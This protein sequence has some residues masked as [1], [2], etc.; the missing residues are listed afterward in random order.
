MGLSQGRTLCPMGSLVRHYGTFISYTL[1]VIILAHLIITAMK[2]NGVSTFCSAARLFF[3]VG[4]QRCVQYRLPV[5]VPVPVPSTDL[6]WKTY[7]VL[8][9][10]G[11]WFVLGTGLYWYWTVLGTGLYWVLDCTGYWIVLGTGLYWVLDCTG[12]GLYW[13][14]DCTGYRILLVLYCTED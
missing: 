6:D 11:Y 1:N 7:W 5:P 4:K 8:D 12:T 3:S 14:L 2:K 13:V 9:C 10:T